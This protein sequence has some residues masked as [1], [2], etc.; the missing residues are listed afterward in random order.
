MKTKSK[1]KRTGFSPETI[2]HHERYRAIVSLINE[3][4]Y[5]R[6]RKNKKCLVGIQRADL[7]H[8]LVKASNLTNNRDKRPGPIEYSTE[9]ALKKINKNT[10]QPHSK[11]DRFLL[12]PIDIMIRSG[13]ISK[14]VFFTSVSGYQRAIERLKKQD[15]IKSFKPA[16]GYSTLVLTEKGNLLFKKC[17]INHLISKED[18]K[19][20]LGRIEWILRSSFNAGI[21]YE[22]GYKK[23]R[24][25]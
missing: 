2:F 3:Y 11:M 15:I 1:R 7:I 24:N 8:F 6:D 22:G 25:L 23:N 10:Y 19:K 13:F 4:Q 9:I 16:K 14:N 5:K 20:I 18:D 12:D 21:L 17:L